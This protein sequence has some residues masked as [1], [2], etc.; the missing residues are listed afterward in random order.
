[1]LGCWNTGLGV[2]GIDHR[3]G[4]VGCLIGIEN[5]RNLLIAAV[6]DESIAM[7][8]GIGVQ[9]LRDLPGNCGSTRFRQ[10]KSCGIQS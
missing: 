9:C 1:V 2:V 5:D 7:L 6:E 8:L 4:D 3:L 10:S